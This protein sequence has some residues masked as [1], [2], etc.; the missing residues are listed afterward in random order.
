MDSGLIREQCSHNESESNMSTHVIIGAGPVAHAT[1]TE[2]LA[3]G[4]AVRSITRSG[5]AEMPEGVDR[6]RADAANEGALVHATR[7]AAAIYNC[8]NP[9]Y[10]KWVTQWPP[11]A[12]ALLNAAEKHDAV[13]VTMSN[14][15]GYGPSRRPFRETDALAATGAK[16]RVRAAM[17]E[18]AVAAHR[19]GRVRVTEARAS[20]FIG[21][22]VLDASMGSRVV[23]NVLAGKAVGLMGRLDVPHAVTAM[24]DVGTAMAILGT[25]DR[26]LGRAWHVPTAPAQTQREIVAGLCRAAGVPMVKARAMPGIALS[27]GGVFVPFLRELREVAYQFSAPFD[28][29]SSDFTATFGVPPTPLDRTYSETVTWFRTRAK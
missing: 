20:D 29:E 19:A 24:G 15:Y 26:A 23:D 1:A 18:Q 12:T 13:L 8:A 7:D 27:L 22:R 28:L 14:L 21:P 25:D 5:G 2:L 3:K 17:W 9:P 16:G 10:D 11:I 6:E 4:H